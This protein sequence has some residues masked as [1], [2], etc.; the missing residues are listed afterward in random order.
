MLALLFSWF[1]HKYCRTDFD[2]A[3]T[4]F[5][6]DDARSIDTFPSTLKILCSSCEN[7]YVDGPY[8]SSRK[9]R[10]KSILKYFASS[11]SSQK[12]DYEGI[13]DSLNGSK[14]KNLGKEVDKLRSI[15]SE[16]EL[17][18][19]RAA[20]DISGRAHAKVLTVIY[21]LICVYIKNFLDHEIH[22]P[23]TIRKRCCSAF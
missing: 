19:M 18:V 13:M 15:K 16:A 21:S 22:S 14:R 7:V 6:A 12:S 23:R 4:L 10:P 3:A 2:Q 8:M 1:I 17:R 5:G 9:G 11:P 20:A